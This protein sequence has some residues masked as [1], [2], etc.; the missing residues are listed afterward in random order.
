MPSPP[1]ASPP[2][3][4]D[5]I[6]AFV[7]HHVGLQGRVTGILGRHGPERAHRLLEIG[8]AIVSQDG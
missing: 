2:D 3:P 4:F 8:M 5:E 7:R 1:P 6:E